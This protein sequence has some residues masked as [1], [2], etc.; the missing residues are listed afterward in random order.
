MDSVGK[1]GEEV[2]DCLGAAVE[3]EDAGKG[4]RYVLFFGR[5][6]SWAELGLGGWW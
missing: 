3:V 6:V 5:W 2:V 4:A 1:G